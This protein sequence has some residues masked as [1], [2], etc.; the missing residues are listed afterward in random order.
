MDEVPYFLWSEG[1]KLKESELREKLRSPDPAVRGLW[2]GHILR[3]ANFPEVWQ[4]VSLAD[5]LRDWPVI[6]RHLGRMR[7]FWHFMLDGWRRL[8]LIPSQ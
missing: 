2:I 6:E 4:F 5:V 8:G 7:P 1:E 3:E